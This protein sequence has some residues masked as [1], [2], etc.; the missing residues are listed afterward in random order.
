MAYFVTTPQIGVAG[1]NAVYTSGLLGF[2]WVSA[3]VNPLPSAA[4]EEMFGQIIS[5][6]STDTTVGGGGEFI[7]LQIPTS[8]TVT[9]GLFYTWDGAYKIAVVATTQASQANSGRPIALAINTVSSNG[10]SNQATWFQ[11]QGRGTA[12]RSTFT[13]LNVQPN[14]PLYVSAA[15]AGRIRSTASVFRTIIGLRSA[16]VATVA[17]NVS[18]LLVYLNRP[19]IGPGI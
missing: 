9:P 17:S 10:T 13:T 1:L 3:T 4:I 15:T 12:L 6:Q 18:T 5:A 11:V 7:F 8:T 2:P 19:N 14:I 16:N